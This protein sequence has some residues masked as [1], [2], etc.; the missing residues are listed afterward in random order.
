METCRGS[1]E[2]ISRDEIKKEIFVVVGNSGY[3]DPAPTLA[4]WAVHAQA[5]CVEPFSRTKD[6]SSSTQTRSC[7]YAALAHGTRSG[8]PSSRG[9]RW[10]GR[11]GSRAPVSDHN[12]GFTSSEC[13]DLCG[14]WI[15][16]LVFGGDIFQSA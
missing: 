15:G 12:Y 2:A 4:C 1:I 13:C 5:P 16:T 11:S 8:S 10:W 6:K 3:Y 9:H 14:N 7:R